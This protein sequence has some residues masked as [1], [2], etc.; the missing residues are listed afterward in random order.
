MSS[1]FI[2]F[3]SANLH[4]A[5]IPEL[6][7]ELT[8]SILSANKHLEDQ[9]VGELI[10]RLRFY[11]SNPFR[12]SPVHGIIIADKHSIPSL[13]GPACLK[14]VSETP[15]LSVSGCGSRISVVYPI[16]GLSERQ[17]NRLTLGFCAMQSHWIRLQGLGH[18][19][20]VCS[21]DCSLKWLHSWFEAD[22]MF[23]GPE[24]VVTRV[25]YLLAELLKD[26]DGSLRAVMSPQCWEWTTSEV[27]EA[28]AGLRDG[29]PFLRV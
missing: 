15:M 20:A 17:V 29:E 21:K 23:V 26:G 16:Q 22:Q 5:T 6:E 10:C 1:I 14:L 18:R 28:L 25:E 13:L 12:L 4:A 24:C 3:S 9:I 27:K 7:Q 11:P 8:L 2:L 19:V